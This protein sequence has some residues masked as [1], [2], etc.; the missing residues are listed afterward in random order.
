MKLLLLGFLTSL[1][2]VPPG[3]RTWLSYELVAKLREQIAL[4]LHNK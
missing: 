1:R 4:V 3:N 2:D